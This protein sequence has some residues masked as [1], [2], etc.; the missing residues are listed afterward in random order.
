MKAFQG[1]CFND[2]DVISQN[3]W[4]E[5]DKKSPFRSAEE[6]YCGENE[7][8]GTYP[9]D[10]VLFIFPEGKEGKEITKAHCGVRTTIIK[11]MESVDRVY[12]WKLDTINIS[13]MYL[14][15]CFPYYK[16]PLLSI[17]INENGLYNLKHSKTF[18]FAI[19]P[20]GKR[21]VGTGGD[22]YVSAIHGQDIEMYTLL[23]I[24]NGER[25][26]KNT[27]RIEDI[28]EIEKYNSPSQSHEPI[29]TN[30]K[31][32]A[33]YVNAHNRYPKYDL[34]LC[35]FFDTIRRKIYSS[36][37]I[38]KFEF[39]VKTD[40][41]IR[42]RVYEVD[43][44]SYTSEVKIEFITMVATG[45]LLWSVSIKFNND[46]IETVFNP[47]Y[48]FIAQFY[49]GTPFTSSTEEDLGE[50]I[51]ELHAT[52][53]EGSIVTF[54]M[55]SGQIVR[56]IRR[57]GYYKYYTS[58]A[59]NIP[60]SK[61]RNFNTLLPRIADNIDK[62][63]VYNVYYDINVILPKEKYEVRTVMLSLANID[64][65]LYLI[66]AEKITRNNYKIN[67]YKSNDSNPLLTNKV[68][69]S[70]NSGRPYRSESKLSALMPI[71]SHTYVYAGYT[72][73]IYEFKTSAPISTLYDFSMNEVALSD[74][75]VYILNLL[76]YIQR[77]EAEEFFK[78]LSGQLLKNVLTNV[79]KIL[80]GETSLEVKDM[81]HKILIS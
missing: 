8:F 36:N 37:N 42:Y 72:P 68:V 47:K 16:F 23:P 65:Y 29:Y 14:K 60:Q 4:S 12:L 55:K 39:L 70:F 50:Y 49:L 38:E 43:G 21:Y 7:R 32:Q 18:L 51:E 73:T 15:L 9:C 35:Q 64:R 28:P 2:R 66:V 75:K 63:Q 17:H 33:E 41:N 24:D 31:K 30:I 11:S 69:L 6:F 19:R 54:L 40:D 25:F 76:V 27:L 52:E 26:I 74:D 48:T 56:F 57:E 20:I 80:K 59:S 78:S 5:A 45:E 13:N 53:E 10:P 62:I 67:V 77:K 1:K 46:K 79:D 22:S 58:R 81:D 44:H 71:N 61:L 3:D 34:K